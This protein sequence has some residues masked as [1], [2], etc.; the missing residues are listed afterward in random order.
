MDFDIGF[1]WPKLLGLILMLLWLCFSFRKV[2]LYKY[3]DT[4]PGK[5]DR[6]IANPDIS[7]M[8]NQI[9]II[10]FI[11]KGEEVTIEHFYTGSKSDYEGEVTICVDK[12]KP[13]R[14]VVKS[15][16]PSLF[17][18]FFLPIIISVLII[19]SYCRIKGC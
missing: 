18:D 3:A 2:Y 17:L 4:V 13:V 10:K 9:A 6:V 5:V 7:S 14:S 16:S 15:K 19:I 11:Y 1:A 8:Q 12:A